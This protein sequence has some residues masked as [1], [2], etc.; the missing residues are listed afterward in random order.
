MRED[1]RLW[2]SDLG[3]LSFS[4]DEKGNWGYK[5]EGADTVIPFKRESIMKN[6]GQVS[7]GKHKCRFCKL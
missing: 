6:Y 1:G 7:S 3:G 2:N 5:P 4:I